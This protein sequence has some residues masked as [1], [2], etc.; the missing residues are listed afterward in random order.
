MPLAMHRWTLACLW[1]PPLPIVLLKIK[2][3]REATPRARDAHGAL[4]VLGEADSRAAHGGVPQE[5]EAGAGT[6]CMEEGEVQEEEQGLDH[7]CCV[8]KRDHKCALGSGCDAPCCY[9]SEW[10]LFFPV[11]LRRTCRYGN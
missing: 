11:L 7:G 6:S 8:E 10:F 3:A 5:Q 2:V 1:R 9:L 4:V